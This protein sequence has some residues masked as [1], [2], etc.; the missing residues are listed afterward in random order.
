MYFTIVVIILLITI[1]MIINNNNVVTGMAVI[2]D[3]ASKTLWDS[4]EKLAKV[5]DSFKNEFCGVITAQSLVPERFTA[6]PSMMPTGM[7]ASG[8][9]SQRN[10]NMIISTLIMFVIYSLL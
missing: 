7:G 1:M 4:V 5:P 6:V 10:P 9:A 3:V 8:S 2:S